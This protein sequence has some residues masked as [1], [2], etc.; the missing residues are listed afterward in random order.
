MMEEEGRYRGF[1]LSDSSANESV[2]V[3]S[4]DSE[5]DVSHP[6]AAAIARDK[7]VPKNPSENP[8]K[9]RSSEKLLKKISNSVRLLEFPNEYL[10][11]RDGNLFCGACKQWLSEKKSA[12]TAHIATK[13]HLDVK[14]GKKKEK[15]HQQSMMESLD[16]R[17]KAERPVGETLP[18][19][20]RAFRVEIMTNFLSRIREGIPIAKL[21]GLRPIMERNNFSLTR[22]SHMV[23]YIPFILSEEK[24]RIKSLLRD[25]NIGIIFDGTTRL[26][27]AIAIVVRF[28]DG[29]TVRQV[30]VRLHIVAKP[31]TGQDL[32]KVINRCLALEYQIDGECVVAAM[33]DGASVN[34]VAIRTLQVLYPNVFDVTCFSHTA[35]NAGHHF[36]FPVLEKIH[37]PLDPAIQPQ[38]KGKVGLETKNVVWYQVI[39]GDKMVVAVGSNAPGIH[40]LW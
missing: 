19:E 31:V 23:E 24:A 33:R 7:A 36:Q 10:E 21:D 26:D 29:W 17:D 5:D 32:A 6:A 40:M 8:K 18:L 22:P 34:G 27:E 38:L 13:K 16:A 15:S 14:I 12:V 37:S 2:F 3:S 39:L 1:D 11:R 9:K 35:N 4:D 28:L 25:K 20:H 30:L